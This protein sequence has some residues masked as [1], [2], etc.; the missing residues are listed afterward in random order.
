[1]QCQVK[2]DCLEVIGDDLYR[3]YDDILTMDIQGDKLTDFYNSVKGIYGKC[4]GEVYIDGDNGEAIHIGYTFIK[5]EGG[6]LFEYWLVPYTN[7]KVIYT[8]LK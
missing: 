4:S 1:M 6:S 3:C 8:Y 5:Q 2:L 7:R